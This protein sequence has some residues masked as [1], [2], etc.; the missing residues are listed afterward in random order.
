MEFEYDYDVLA[1]LTLLDSIASKGYKKTNGIYSVK[2]LPPFQFTYESSG[3]DTRVKNIRSE[4]LENLPVG[5]DDKDYQWVDLYKE[6]ISGIL[7]EQPPGLFYKAN[8]GGGAFEK[9]KLVIPKPSFSGVR[10]GLLQL[11]DLEADGRTFVV[12][13]AR[14]HPGYFEL[15][16]DVDWNNFRNF[17]HI[18]NVDFANPNIKFIDL[19]G[20]GKADLLV[21]EDE[22][23]CWYPSKGIEGYDDY[24]FVKKEWDEEKGPPIIFDDNEQSIMLADMSGDGLS[25]IVRIRNGEIVYWPNLGYGR[26]GAKVVMDNAPFM[27]SHELFNLKN[28]RLA[29]INGL[30]STDLVYLDINTC[31]VWFN[32]NGNGWSTAQAINPFPSFDNSAHVSVIDLLGHGTSCIVW[33]SPLPGN[34]G[35]QLR[36]IDLMGGKKP[37]ILTRYEN[38][39]GKRVSV[40][41]KPS[42]YYYLKDKKEGRHWITKLAF[43]VQCV[44]TVVTE[45]L[46]YVNGQLIPRLRFTQ[47]FTYHHGYYD[48]T[49]REFRGFGRVEQTDTEDFDHFKLN[50]VQ[51]V[52]REDLH[53]SPV[54]TITWYHTGAWFNREKILGQFAKEYTIGSLEFDLPA[55]ILPEGLNAEE[56]REAFRAFKGIALR[57]EVYSVDGSAAENIPY[58]SAYH[59][60]FIK[61]LQPK[62]EN[63]YAVFLVQESEAVTYHYERDLDDPRIEHAFNLDIDEYGNVRKSAAV[64]YG[65]N[66]SDAGLP[67]SIRE[68]QNKSHIIFAESDITN[69]IDLPQVYRLPLQSASRTYELTGLTPANDQ[70]FNF[71]E[72]EAAFIS[73]SEIGYGEIANNISLQK[74]LTEYVRTVYLDNDLI[75]PLPPDEVDSL[76][77]VHQSYQLANTPELVIGIYGNK[78][79]DAMLEAAGYVHLNDNNWWMPS[80]KNVFLRTGETVNDSRS[81]FYQPVGVLD[82]CGKET[83]LEYDAYNLMLISTEDALQNKT[84]SEVVDYRVMH[85][86]RLKD[87]ND[88]I[89]E[90]L[91]DELGMVIVTSMHGEETDG[92]K[93]DA[94][95]AEYIIQPVSDLD[96]VISDPH[97]YLQQAT[98]FFYYDLFAFINQQQPPCVAGIVRETHTSNLPDNVQSKLQLNV[99][100]SSGLG[101]N[102]QGKIQAEPGRA[103]KWENDQLIEIE[104]TPN[105]RWVGSGRVIMN[106][107]GNPVKQY[108]PFFSTT[109]RYESE[110]EIVEV[111]FS[112]ILHYDPLDRQIRVEH[113]N[114]TFT[115]TIFNVWNEQSFDE[116]D[117][118]LRSSWYEDRGSP[119]PAIVEP[120]DAEIRAAWLSAKHAETYTASHLDSLGR[121]IYTVVDNGVEG[122]YGT[123]IM[124]DIEGNKQQVIDGRQNTIIRYKYNMAGDELYQDSADAGESW[125][126]RNVMGDLISAWNITGQK[127]TTEYDDLYRPVNLWLVED[128]LSG[129]TPLL[130][131]FSIY[132]ENQP[133]DK[134]R[135]LRGKLFQSFDQAGMIETADCDFKGNSKIS[136]QRLTIEYKTLVDW[137]VPDPFS[138]LEN[139]MF[140]STFQMDAVSRPVQITLPDGSRS[141][142]TYNEAGLLK[143]LTVFVS[144]QNETVEFVKNITY[145]AKGMRERIVY[146]NNT[147]TRYSYEP[148]RFRLTRLLT[149][150]NNGADILQDLIYT[151]DPVGNITEIKDDAQQT[152]FF[153]NAAVDPGC[154]YYYDAIYRLKKVIGR[155]HAGQNRACDQFDKDKTHFLN[156]T[157]LTLKGDMNA[158]QRYEQAYS[159]DEAGNLLSM[160][161][162]AGNAGFVHRWTRSFNYS[163][164][165][166]QLLSTTVSGDTINYDYDVRGNMLN[167][168]D[169]LFNLTWDYSD[170]LKEMDL[171]GGGKAFYVYSA[172][173]ARTRKV[174][175][176]GNLV[177]ERIYL[178]GYELYRERLNNM[179]VLERETLH[180]VDDKQRVAL[181]ESRTQG[182]DA[183]LQNLTRY[184]YGNHLGT[185]CLEVSGDSD[186][187]QIISYEEFYPYGSSAY[188]AVRNQ[189][190]TPKRYR[191][192]SKECDDESG[193]YYHGDR[194]Y[195]PWLA[196]WTAADPMGID[197]GIN[198]Y[199]YVEARPIIAVDPTG[200]HPIV[201][202]IL[203]VI[204]ATVTAVSEAGAPTNEEDAK[205]VKPHISDAEFAAHTAVTG[206]SMAVGG[207]ASRAVGGGNVILKGMVDGMVSGGAQALGDQALEDAKKGELSSARTYAD[208]AVEN[209]ASG[210]VVGGGLAVAGKG[211]KAAKGVVTGGGKAA[212][213][214]PAPK[215]APKGAEPKVTAPDAPPAAAPAPSPAA[216]ATKPPVVAEAAAAPKPPKPPK[217]PKAPGGAKPKSKNI[218]VLKRQFGDRV[219]RGEGGRPE[220]FTGKYGPGQEGG[221]GT[222]EQARSSV[223]TVTEGFTVDY[224][225]GH[226]RASEM[227]GKGG[228]KNTF[229]QMGS[230]NTGA[231]RV[232]ESRLAALARSAAPG[233][234]VYYSLNFVYKTASSTVPEYVVARVRINGTTVRAYFS[235]TE[236]AMDEVGK[237]TF[238]K[239]KLP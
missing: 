40:E 224:H 63:N 112:S 93:G 29:D 73:A 165:N 184:Q 154:K 210:A 98:T 33:S 197:G 111:G 80:G 75:T 180:I 181:V 212:P 58:S 231:F 173:G 1:G 168:E 206:V 32:L 121:S 187:P 227:G 122:I 199:V 140:T 5:I 221:T 223:R 113:P 100:Y 145:S 234:K 45:D 174:I 185:V 65:R 141:T 31:N 50:I 228:L 189:T 207:V 188:K 133:N 194:Y 149:T 76:G 191:F 101:Q 218:T 123:T 177:K 233:D 186:D 47:R 157:L 170:H 15:G 61:L 201:F 126:L 225:A 125:V 30:G 203:V 95:L 118:V 74:R 88:N 26:F 166:N 99:G 12:S 239:P 159:Y 56:L 117:T 215:A 129:T 16:E 153:N 200:R 34:S 92:V 77:F 179:L 46:E 41:Y 23:F 52:V 90:I 131:A 89:V 36:Y 105:P 97:K 130:T 213:K 156:N 57:Q 120:V 167:L 195:A 7:S 169:G 161:H 35:R 204:V 229:P 21:S 238:T 152:V 108:E 226:M 178:G 237:M 66:I 116:N 211:I 86:T 193:L 182:N 91:T 139:E 217:P 230:V 158:M 11:Q 163:N 70:Y 64:V 127:I 150:R 22:V 3:W 72:L 43:P 2:E 13:Y 138:L 44:D 134:L 205:N 124:L 37:F 119:D 196:R 214:A 6:G 136:V 132:G 18:P 55:P 67:Q 135:N 81:R 48:H 222:T 176:T 96:D 42:T 54:K 220:T 8:L 85:G 209:A 14:E 83:K 27:A 82:A 49:E 146:G 236:A 53:Q 20:D 17:L 79:N 148:K 171:G 87:Q 106:N 208:K 103:F 51:N 25:D 190:E 219:R 24:R 104:T 115:E 62:Q 19:N 10:S 160:I 102:I 128:D 78:M 198:L 38:N 155:E 68:Q 162:N 172:G 144:R 59:S 39:M 110:K 137:N 71:N 109:H 107:K 143:N 175:E 94:P 142:P 4:E 232:F 69:Q 151:Y 84:V 114:G 147:A 202:I 183:G 28:I 216:A 164:N 60:C 192:T 235:N 9:K